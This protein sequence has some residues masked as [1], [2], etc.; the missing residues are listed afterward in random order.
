MRD[1]HR[2][3][4]PFDDDRLVDDDA[5]VGLID[6]DRPFDS[7]TLDRATVAASSIEAPGVTLER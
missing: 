3:T 4:Q 7:S 1:G 2:R 6:R 5:E